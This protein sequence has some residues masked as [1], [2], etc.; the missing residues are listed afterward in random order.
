MAEQTADARI[1]D[2]VNTQTTKDLTAFYDVDK[3]G[4]D[5]AR[6][7][8]GNTQRVL[9]TLV[10]DSSGDAT[11]AVDFTN[12]E[13][14][15]LTVNQASNAITVTMPN[16]TVVYLLVDKSASNLVTFTG[17]TVADA[18][19]V[20]ASDLFYKI[21]NVSGIKYIERIDKQ[22]ESSITEGNT[23][24]DIGNISSFDHLTISVQDKMAFVH[25]QFTFIANATDTEIGIGFTFPYTLKY[26]TNSCDVY[27][28]GKMTR[29]RLSATGI[30]IICDP[31]VT[32]GDTVT[33]YI[34]SL[35][36]IV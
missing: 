21:S 12:Y 22:Y 7:E 1:Y 8:S 14:I 13:L 16:N 30:T 4:Y 36:P 6:K 2:Y 26:T 27:I 34:N 5:A 31:T 9:A 25:G 32:S 3:S 18:R 10:Q 15:I 24:V 19:Q 17:S 28:A 23:T 11:P 20:G 35:V 33:V 29:Q